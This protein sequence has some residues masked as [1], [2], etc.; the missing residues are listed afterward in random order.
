MIRAASADLSVLDVIV[1]LRSAASGKS[2]LG[3]A[4]DAEEREVLVLG[5]LVQTLNVVASWPACRRIH[6]VSDEART[7]ELLR[8][9]RP[10]LNL[11]PEPDGGGLNAALRA[12]RGA[13]TA[14]GA[15]AVLMLPADLPL[16]SRAALD[17]LL[18]AADA[19]IAAGE[20]RP[21]TVIA[22]ADARA[23]TNALLL[24][25]A[26]AIEPHFGDDS[27]EAHLRAA[28]AAGA[29]VQLVIDPV[30]GFDLDT[31]DDLERLDL[32][33]LLELQ[34]LGQAA[35]SGLQPAGAEVG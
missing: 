3:L 27:L 19:A 12:A 33:L 21:V 6:L 32:A 16:L 35:L 20:G 22:P 9:A 24:S 28:A 8:R 31:P 4:L 15:T 7:V 34:D 2:R 30:L 18:V 26:G 14:A 29:S 25:P 17:G 5:M 1:P 23:G 10:A 13:A 11:V